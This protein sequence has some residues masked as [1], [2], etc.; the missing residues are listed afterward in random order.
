[1]L[2]CSWR[3]GTWQPYPALHPNSHSRTWFLVFMHTPMGTSPLPQEKKYERVGICWPLPLLKPLGLWFSKSSLC[4]WEIKPEMQKLHC[5]H[6]LMLDLLRDTCHCAWKKHFG[7][8]SLFQTHYFTLTMF[9]LPH[10]HGFAFSDLLSASITL[11]TE[12]QV[13]IGYC[14]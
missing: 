9:S 6:W 13:I 3:I 4:G 14:G 2:Y 11:I 10:F 8:L 7:W 1:M 12:D 5:L